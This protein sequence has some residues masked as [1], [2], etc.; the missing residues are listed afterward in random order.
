MYR[1]IEVKM[2]VYDEN[3]TRRSNEDV[4]LEFDVLPK[5]NDLIKVKNISYIV[6]EI[7][8]TPRFKEDNMKSWTLQN[9]KI[10]IELYVVKLDDN[11]LN[12]SIR[13]TNLYK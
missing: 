12:R 9:Q 2:N 10:S 1:Q 7:I 4:Y 13:N 3:G 8:H 11:F 6:K 5:Q